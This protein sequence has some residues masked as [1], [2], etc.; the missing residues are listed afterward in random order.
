[1]TWFNV[2]TAIATW[3]GIVL[4]LFVYF[5]PTYFA[6]V[7]KKGKAI[8]KFFLLNLLLGWTAIGWLL[9][10]WWGSED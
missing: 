10:I 1:M 8:R 4:I 7:T 9:L 3:I 2:G 6:S 5:L